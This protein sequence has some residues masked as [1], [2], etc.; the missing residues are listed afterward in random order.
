MNAPY[1]A[2]P[3]WLGLVALGLATINLAQAEPEDSAA[4]KNPSFEISEQQITALD[5]QLY[6]LQSRQQSVQ[7]R[8][9]AQVVVPVD[10]EQVITAPV[11]GLITQVL[12]QPYQK[13][14]TNTPLLR[15]VSP[16]LGQLQLSLL[17]ANTQRVLARQTLARE[18]QLYREGI[19]P[20]RRIQEAQASLSTA[21]A[22]LNQAKM[23]L[24]LAGFSPKTLETVLSTGKPQEGLTL[25]APQAGVVTNL[26]ARA[27]QRVDLTT[28]LIHLAQTEVLWLDI[29]LPASEHMRWATGTWIDITGYNLKAQITQSSPNVNATNQSLTLRARIEGNTPLLH[30]GE[31]VSVALPAQTDATGWDAPL[32]AL[33]YQDQQAYVFLRT[34]TGFEA[35]PVTLLASSGAWVR[36]QGSLPPDAQIAASKVVALKGAWLGHLEQDAP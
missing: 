15:L 30:P 10:A 2:I 22:A 32:T 20:E 23:A 6:R 34:A 35:K 12:V 1:R 26:P 11:A 36:I 13:V 14:Q 16:D 21:E 31:L 4:P 29:Q 9:P 3:Q 27:G 25:T 18:H 24:R 28:P 19:T 5:I 17:Q 8:F 33:A 7:M